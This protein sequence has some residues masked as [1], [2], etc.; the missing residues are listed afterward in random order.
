M[1]VG[2]SSQ[3][4]LKNIPASRPAYPQERKQLYDRVSKNATSPTFKRHTSVPRRGEN[5]LSDTSRTSNNPA[6]SFVMLTESQVVP[7]SV[8]KS[9]EDT[10]PKKRT[11]EDLTFEVP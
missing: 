11:Q 1:I 9:P 10:N 7:P 5:T 3:Q 6:M 4:Q 8:V 2:T